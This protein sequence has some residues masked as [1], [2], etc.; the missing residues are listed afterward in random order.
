MSFRSPPSFNAHPPLASS[1]VMQ[2]QMIGL[3]S[4][5]D[6]ILSAIQNQNQP[7][8]QP[9]RSSPVISGPLPPI[10]TH[11]EMYNSSPGQGEGPSRR[12]FPPLPG[13]APPVR[14]EHS[15]SSVPLVA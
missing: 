15:P 10:R 12:T 4:S 2:S 14:D 3:Q 11:S 7:V 9:N 13:F 1:Q 6:R 8:V 5:L